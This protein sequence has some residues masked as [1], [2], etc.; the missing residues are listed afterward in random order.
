MG[1]P[2]GTLSPKRNSNVMLHA[3]DLQ[4]IVMCVHYAGNHYIPSL[5]QLS[6]STCGLKDLGLRI[7]VLTIQ[8]HAFES[9]HQLNI[10]NLLIVHLLICLYLYKFWTDIKYYSQVFRIL[11][12]SCLP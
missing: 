5:K 8:C 1:L 9:F 4:Q 10:I 6:V 2:Q 7:S 12:C 11:M 3:E